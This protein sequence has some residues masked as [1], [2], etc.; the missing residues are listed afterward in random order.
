MSK[1]FFN[2]SKSTPECQRLVAQYSEEE[3]DAVTK[4]KIFKRIHELI[5]PKSQEILILNAYKYKQNIFDYSMKQ[6]EELISEA[7]M[8]YL[9]EYDPL[10]R[11]RYASYQKAAHFDTYFY[12]QLPFVITAFIKGKTLK[13]YQEMLIREQELKKIER[14]A[15]REAL[16]EERERKKR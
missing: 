7:L 1:K 14:E 5:F 3:I 15:E 13:Q 12:Q 9:E 2:I 4:G 11:S 10:Y 6:Y 8:Y 16:K